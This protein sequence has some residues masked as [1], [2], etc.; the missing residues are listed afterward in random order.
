MPLL[1]A[2]LGTPLVSAR[3]THA[4]TYTHYLHRSVIS[5]VFSSSTEIFGTRFGIRWREKK[6]ELEEEEDDILN[7]KFCVLSIAAHDT[8]SG[9]ELSFIGF[10]GR[11]SF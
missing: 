10:G 9:E 6:E 8:C 2:G 11:S 1:H 5:Y 7:Q 3:G 4:P